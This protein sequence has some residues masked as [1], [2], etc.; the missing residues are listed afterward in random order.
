[1]Q[2]APPV[3]TATQKAPPKTKPKTANQKAKPKTA[4][5]K[6]KP[7]TA[8][9]KAKPKTATQKAKPKTATQKAKPKT[10]TQKAKPKTATQKAKPKT[11][12]GEIYIKE[13]G[14]MHEKLKGLATR[15]GIDE[16]FLDDL[17]DVEIDIAEIQQ[18]VIDLEKA[19]SGLS[20]KELDF[21]PFLI[22][23]YS[24]GTYG[25]LD[26]DNFG[27]ALNMK[28]DM[29][30]DLSNMK[31]MVEELW[32][33][34]IRQSLKKLAGEFKLELKIGEYLDLEYI[35]RG[36]KNLEAII[37]AIPEE[38]LVVLREHHVEIYLS[39]DSLYR[40]THVVL[41]CRMDYHEM[42]SDLKRYIAKL[43]P[44]KEFGVTLKNK[45][46]DSFGLEHIEVNDLLISANLD[47]IKK[48]GE[49]LEKAL[50]KLPKNQFDLVQKHNIAISLSLRD[51]AN[52]QYV[53]L[54]YE[55]DDAE[56]LSALQKL[57]PEALEYAAPQNKL[58]DL[59]KEFNLGTLYIARSLE[60]EHWNSAVDTL[61]SVLTILPEEQL[62]ALREHD[63]NIHLSSKN[64]YMGGMALQLDGTNSFWGM[65]RDLLNL[66]PDS[67][68]KENPDASTRERIEGLS[69][70]TLM[71]SIRFLPKDKY[72]EALLE[73]TEVE[74]KKALS[75]KNFT[76]EERAVL[77]DKELTI[78]GN[79]LT[80]NVR[81]YLIVGYRSDAEQ[82][83]KDIKARILQQQIRKKMAPLNKNYRKKYAPLRISVWS[84]ADYSTN[85]VQQ[86]KNLEP[87]LDQLKKEGL[88]VGALPPLFINNTGPSWNSLSTNKQLIIYH[89]DRPSA[90][91]KS[92]IEG[93][94]QFRIM[95]ELE[96]IGED[97]NGNKHGIFM[98]NNEAY[99]YK[100]VE[101]H[102]PMIKEALG[103]IKADTELFEKV[104]TYR[105]TLHEK[106]GRKVSWGETSG[107]KEKTISIDYAASA[108]KIVE[109]IRALFEG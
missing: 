64:H 99:D 29:A 13:F 39:E 85:I 108:D 104:K 54:N 87:I 50:A 34:K 56:M 73:K 14:E 101:K 53:Y 8:T 77:R 48:A 92:I 25:E 33:E 75:P 23:G 30:K 32:L 43:V 57:I 80:I 105:I 31:E 12:P 9:Q 82:M 71:Y 66:I 41:D 100:A 28:G 11:A 49:N 24:T 103:K 6:A 26:G 22:L 106:P 59:R 83:V 74:L 61:E 86:F 97:F 4:T 62:S 67:K 68:I 17:D 65:S 107:K 36:A 78:T 1:T 76:R 5:Q 40:R 81:H 44:F 102:L 38:Q 109:G 18:G 45:M 89:G 2:K 16:I 7:K 84:D 95:K 93:I 52:G 60:K 96:K 69:K 47:N 15:F 21:I 27:L 79:N 51:H 91:R 90:I 3:K 42:G 70:T 20:K 98:W 46:K 88:F 55:G 72:Y 94:T 58:N 10:A 35:K 19:L 37:R 63:I